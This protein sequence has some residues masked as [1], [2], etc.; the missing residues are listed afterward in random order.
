[1]SDFIIAIPYIGIVDNWY[2][3]VVKVLQMNNHLLAG[4]ILSTGWC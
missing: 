3:P 2:R 1:M 4:G